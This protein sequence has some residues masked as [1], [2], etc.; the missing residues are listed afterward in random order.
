MK[1][2]HT[3]CLVAEELDILSQFTA[4]N[5]LALSV[6]LDLRS[7]H[8]QQRAADTARHLIQAHLK[9]SGIGDEAMEA[10]QEDLDVIRLYLTTNGGRDAEGVAMFSCAAELFWRVYPLSAPVSNVV[11]VGPRFNVRPL[12]EKLDVSCLDK[13]AQEK[14]IRVTS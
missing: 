5:G 7:T 11:H 3:N 2:K 4:Q 14:P 6:Y 10:L 9:E 12:L 1:R 13:I 8:A